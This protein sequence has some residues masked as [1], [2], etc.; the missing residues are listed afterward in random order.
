LSNYV[1][2]YFFTSGVLCGS[3]CISVRV[4]YTMFLWILSLLNFVVTS[5]SLYLGLFVHSGEV[6]FVVFG[7][8]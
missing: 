1:K 7:M 5:M 3:A 2:T 8:I 6:Y 4:F